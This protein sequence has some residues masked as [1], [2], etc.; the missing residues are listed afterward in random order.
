MEE[1]FILTK[2]ALRISIMFLPL[3]LLIAVITKDYGSMII[4]LLFLG[5]NIFVFFIADFMILLFLEDIWKK[6]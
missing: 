1:N 2:I 3:I 6:N 4:P 5:A